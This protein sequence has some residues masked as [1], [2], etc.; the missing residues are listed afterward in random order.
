MLLYVQIGHRFKL[1]RS[2]VRPPRL[3]PCP[4]SLAVGMLTAGFCTPSSGTIGMSDSEA[5]AIW[6]KV[7]NQHSEDDVTQR[8]AKRRGY[9]VLLFSLHVSMDLEH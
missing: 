1:L 2:F 5:V 4:L 8:F 3:G 9:R 7:A 6:T